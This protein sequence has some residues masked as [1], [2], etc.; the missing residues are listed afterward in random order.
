MQV[1]TAGEVQIDLAE[2]YRSARKEVE[3]ELNKTVA[4]GDYGV[5][6]SKWALIYI[7]LPEDDSAFPEVRRYKK[8][9][10]VVEFRLKV[11][12][13]AFK[14]SDA[15]T[16]RKLLAASVRRSIDLSGELKIADF[17]VGHFKAD[18]IQVLTKNEWA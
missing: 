4:S 7:I 14:E 15:R 6:V 12:Y 9:T 16:Q 3:H 17:D 10:G 5:G 18:V 8:R 2:T 1:W 13:Q 11:D